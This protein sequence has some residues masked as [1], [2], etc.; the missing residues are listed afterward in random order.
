MQM[1]KAA[2]GDLE[3]LIPAANVSEYG[4]MRDEVRGMLEQTPDLQGMQLRFRRIL[5]DAPSAVSAVVRS[6]YRQP[7]VLP[8]DVIDGNPESIQR[9]IDRLHNPILLVR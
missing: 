2:A 8:V 4:K 7:I 1:A 6:E 5:T 9:L 3:I